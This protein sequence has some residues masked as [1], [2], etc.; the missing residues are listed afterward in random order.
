M[1]YEPLR[2]VTLSLL[3]IVKSNRLLLGEYEGP[4]NISKELKRAESVLEQF[5]GEDEEAWL[6]RFASVQH[7]KA[8]VLTVMAHLGLPKSEEKRRE[9]LLECL[10]SE[11]INLRDAGVHAV[12]IWEDSRFCDLLEHHSDS[13]EWLDRYAKQ[14][15][16]DLR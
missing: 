3:R 7:T 5:P 11:N 12:E 2:Q 8:D 4:E 16:K 9:I 14:V 1:S 15:A 13:A 10:K 6:R